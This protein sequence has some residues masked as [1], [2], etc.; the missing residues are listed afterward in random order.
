MEHMFSKKNL[1]HF[2]RYNHF[3]IFLR[4]VSDS[5]R[6]IKSFKNN[7]RKLNIRNYFNLFIIRTFYGLPY[8]R[9]KI[10]VKQRNENKEIAFTKIFNEEKKITKIINDINING[11]SENLKIKEDYKNEIFKNVIKNL[12]NSQVIYKDKSSKNKILSFNNNNEIIEYLKLNNVH[13]IKNEV[14]ILQ[15]KF[16]LSLF[17]N[18]F[19]LEIAKTYLNT[20]KITFIPSFFISNS[21]NAKSDYLDELNSKSAQKYHFDVDFKKFFK[22]FI[23]FTDVENINDGAHIFIPKSHK[24]KFKKNLITGRF[25]N[26]DI[27][28]N[29]NEK[30]IFLGKS[31]TTFF[32][33]T[34]GIHKGSPVKNNIRLMGIFEYGYGH[35]PWK[36]NCLFI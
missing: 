28:S 16:L 32:V 7:K 1:I 27:E 12:T 21:N 19:F 18:G 33:D 3:T 22:I 34:F 10:K 29:Y 13:I 26:K 5:I 30:K 8:F 24:C 36:D 4:S 23:Y 11:Y 31:G 14:N 35:F 20:D 2:F 6:V 25:E 17:T 15:N 9:N